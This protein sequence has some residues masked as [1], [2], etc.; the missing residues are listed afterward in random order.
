MAYIIYTMRIGGNG[1]T[2]RDQYECDTYHIFDGII[3]FWNKKLTERTLISIHKMDYVRIE[4]IG[5]V[6]IKG[7]EIKCTT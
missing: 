2:Y 1:S 4:D 6:K 3:D 7:D 5:D